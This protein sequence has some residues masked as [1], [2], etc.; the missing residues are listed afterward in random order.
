MFEDQLARTIGRVRSNVLLD[1][2]VLVV[3]DPDHLVPGDVGEVG[4]QAGL[5][6]AGVALDQHRVLA[7]GHDPREVTQVLLHGVSQDVVTLRLG[8]ALANVDPETGNID[9]I[10]V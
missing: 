3:V 5:A 1:V 7:H 4:D 10:L 6:H 2:G 8:L 9:T